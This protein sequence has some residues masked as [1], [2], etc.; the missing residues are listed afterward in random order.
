MQPDPITEA[1]HKRQA[2]ARAD[3][4]K[5]VLVKL[6]DA[7]A[8]A[9]RALGIEGPCA[10]VRVELGSA[11]LVALADSGGKCEVDILSGGRAI[12]VAEHT[13][14]GVRFVSQSPSRPATLA[15]CQAIASRAA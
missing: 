2:D 10:T 12:D 1:A 6:A 5:R 4:C 11:W 8:E 3:E 9:R 15:D 14:E 7:F 13:V